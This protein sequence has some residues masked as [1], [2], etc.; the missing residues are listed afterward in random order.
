MMLRCGFSSWGAPN[1]LDI[2]SS[3]GWHFWKI[4]LCRKAPRWKY[5]RSPVSPPSFRSKVDSLWPGMGAGHSDGPLRWGPTPEAT[6]PPLK[7]IAQ[8]VYR[9]C[10]EVY[11]KMFN[12]VNSICFLFLSLSPQIY[13]L[14]GAWFA[15]QRGET[16]C[17]II[18]QLV[19]NCL[20]LKLREWVFPIQ[21]L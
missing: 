14:Q 11:I 17:S 8:S 4:K 12:S 7:S 16:V 18:W 21:C 3:G 20:K 10:F 15:C 5:P 1:E 6:W 19:T 13:I 2:Q 9:T